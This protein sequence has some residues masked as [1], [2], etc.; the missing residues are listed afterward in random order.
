MR[1]SP[2]ALADSVVRLE[3]LSPAHAGAMRAAVADVSR[4]TFG[5]T[6][7]PTPESVEDYI[8]ARRAQTE[9]GTHLSFVQF[10]AASGRLVG[11][12]SF[13]NAREWPG[14][15]G[16]MAVE[17]GHTWL[18][19]SA[20][21]TALNSAAKLLLFTHAFETLGAQRVELKT[22]ARN[23]RSRAGIAAVGATFEGVLRNWQPS[24]VA[25][26]EDRLRDTAM[27]SITV[28]EWR[29]V[30]AALAARVSAKLVA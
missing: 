14:R 29:D 9:A 27:F 19:P 22:D 16:L 23:A 11:H 2:V 25:G 3:P 15:D 13:T 6:A 24:A 8:A 17:V 10:D 30:K 12:T 7:V 5:Y 26:E 18:V 20:Q 4:D 28:D 1:L 21:G